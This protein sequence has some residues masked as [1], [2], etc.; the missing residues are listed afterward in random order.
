MKELNFC[1]N[2]FY[3]L[4]YFGFVCNDLEIIV[5]YATLQ[6]LHILNRYLS[7]GFKA[8]IGGHN[9]AF[10]IE[11]IQELRNDQDSGILFS[12]IKTLDQSHH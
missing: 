12:N 10:A 8:P 9:F 4:R 6:V 1:K 3:F 5:F 2:I 11:K 7:E